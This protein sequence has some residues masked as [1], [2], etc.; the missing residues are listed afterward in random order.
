[1][2]SIIQT[3]FNYL[4][5]GQE[6]TPNIEWRILYDDAKEINILDL[7]ASD[8]VNTL[9]NIFT[10]VVILGYLAILLKISLATLNKLK[11]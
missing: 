1:M 5:F 10:I 7:T 11:K 9:T 8:L 3:L 6:R 2:I 4:L